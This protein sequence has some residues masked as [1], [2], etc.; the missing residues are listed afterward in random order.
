MPTGAE[1]AAL[2]SGEARYK[3]LFEHASIGIA[4]HELSLNERG[5]VVDYVFSDVNPA[6]CRFIG[7]ERQVVIGRTGRE[8]F[9]T[10]DPPYLDKFSAVAQGGP[11]VQ[12]EAYF[13]PMELHFRV[14]VY[15]PEPNSFVTIYE[16]VSDFRLSEAALQA[17][18][19]ELEEVLIQLQTTQQQ[20]MKHERQ[21]A[22]GQLATGIAHDFNNILTTI[23]GN[24]DLL[25]RSP[26]APAQVRAELERIIK[27][28]QRAGY[29]ANQILDFSRQ[30]VRE[31]STFDLVPFLVETV[32]FFERILPENI[33]ISLDAVSGSCR[34]EADLVQLREMLTNLMLNARD[35]MPNGGQLRVALARNTGKVLE[36]CDGCGQPVEGDWICIAVQDNGSGIE[37]E[38][39]ARI[40]E[41]FI[42]TKIVGPGAGLGMSR[43]L[44]VVQEHAGHIKVDSTPGE[45]TSVRIY[46]PA[47]RDVASEPVIRD[48]PADQTDSGTTIL[49]VEDDP[50]VLEVG[51]GMLAYF[52]YRVLLASNGRQALALYRERRNEIALVLSDM[53]MPD[54]S[55][56]ELF[57]TLQSEDPEL[58]MV[59]MSGYAPGENGAKLM[60][61][62]L[63]GWLQ[64]PMSMKVLAETVTRVL[65]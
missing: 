20:L 3:G 62:G 41:P 12:F 9:G 6:F 48:Q 29:L 61:R 50:A 44:A 31:T 37:A 13:A 53:V 33:R 22:I 55:G 17:K 63:A 4:V 40:F 15:A 36:A 2:S 32:K 27:S 1:D 35:A 38:A 60:A 30:S 65:S 14:G 26:D 49:L 39:L 18:N 16:D 8:L 24:A 21:V 45:G 5:Q 58:K 23:I 7:L 52:G 51:R 19:Q 42:T 28:A 46:L 47:I 25:K 57:D 11:P 64:K 54:M 59:I 43:V 34:V 56:V 10:D